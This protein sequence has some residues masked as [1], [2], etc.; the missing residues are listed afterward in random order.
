MDMYAIGLLLR[1]KTNFI[2]Y[3][4]VSNSALSYNIFN[5]DFE[6]HRNDPKYVIKILRLEIDK[7]CKRV[8]ETYICDIPLSSK[9]AKFFR[10][11]G[12]DQGDNYYIRATK[13]GSEYSRMPNVACHVFRFDA[14]KGT[15]TSLDV[16]TYLTG[17]K[18]CLRS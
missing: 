10:F 16:E 7:D 8:Y 1:I 14:D 13:D 11:D 9:E 3:A 5:G 2:L 18:V 17:I 6:N 12:F 4:I 15:C